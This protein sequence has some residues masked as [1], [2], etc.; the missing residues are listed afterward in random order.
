MPGFG[1]LCLILLGYWAL[2]FIEYASRDKKGSALIAEVA[3]EG[4]VVVSGQHGV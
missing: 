1:N 4:E 2:D 3:R